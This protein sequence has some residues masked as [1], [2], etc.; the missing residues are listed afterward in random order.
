MEIVEV[1]FDEGGGLY[2]EG[3]PVD[4]AGLIWGEVVLEKEGGVG[5]V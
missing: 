1:R 5:G 2:G 3:G 4:G